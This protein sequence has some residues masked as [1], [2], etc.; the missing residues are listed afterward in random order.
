MRHSQIIFYQ[1]E[2]QLLSGCIYFWFELPIFNKPSYECVL[3][4]F[5]GPE[6][7]L[8]LMWEDNT[9]KKP[10]HTSQKNPKTKKEGGRGKEEEN[11]CCL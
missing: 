10:S 6:G 1:G 4:H 2:K 9:T 11:D 3:K 7:A 8:P 5:S